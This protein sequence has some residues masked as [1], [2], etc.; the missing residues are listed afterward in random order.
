M[1]VRIL[2]FSGETGAGKSTLLNLFLGELATELLPVAHM[3]STSAICELK[4][5]PYGKLVIHSRDPEKD[6]ITV[7]LEKKGAAKTISQYVHQ[8][9][10][11]KRSHY[12][13]VWI[14]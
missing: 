10:I 3:S 9:G 5:C 7:D 14:L 2:S 13:Q 6:S 11:Y 1:Y 12:L 4:Y 8:K